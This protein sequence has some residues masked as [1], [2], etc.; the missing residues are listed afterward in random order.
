MQKGFW[1]TLRKPIY[2]L[3]PMAD[4]TDAAFRQMIAKYGKP[5]VIWTEFV[6]VNGL[7]S[8][9]RESLLRDLSYTEGER[10]IVAQIFGNDPDKF[11]QV[12]QLLV[13]LGFDGIDINMGCP[14]R[15]VEKQGGGASLIKD[16]IRAQRIITETM[17]GVNDA[18]SNIPVSVKTR[19]GYN[20]VELDEWLPMLLETKPD[21]ITVHARTRK[22]MSK[23]PANWEYVKQVVKLRDSLSVETLILGNGDVKGIADANEKIASSGADGVMIGRAVFGTP[24]LFNPTSPLHTGTVPEKLSVMIEH[25]R[26]FEKLLGDVKNFSVMKKH[27]KAYV[28]GFDGAKELRQELMDTKSGDEVER[29][30]RGWL[31]REQ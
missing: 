25:T 24:W 31:E 19:I 20:K 9:G 28:H 27:Y 30:V 14:D 26:R 8:P 23:V 10:P 15:N 12:A 17:R 11:Y 13:K 1:N 6:S 18:G 29:I 3:A 7:L 22:E 21:V 2:T 5:D 4:V 16:G